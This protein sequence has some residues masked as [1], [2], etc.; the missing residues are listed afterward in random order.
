MKEDKHHGGAAK[1]VTT[2]GPN[3]WTVLREQLDALMRIRNATAHGDIFKLRKPPPFAEGA[4]WVSSSGGGWSMQQP[5]A[6]TALR[7]VESVYNSIASEL[8]RALSYFDV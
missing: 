8:D 1:G 6:L 2:P 5:H 3:I 7:V 4:L